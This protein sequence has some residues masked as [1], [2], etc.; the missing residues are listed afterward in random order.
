[1][2][3]NE[4]KRWFKKL[5]ELGCGA[6]TMVLNKNSTEDLFGSILIELAKAV[7]KRNYTS[8]NIQHQRYDSNNSHNHKQF[9]KAS[10]RSHFRIGMFRT[11]KPHICGL[12]EIIAEDAS[13]VHEINQ[14][15]KPP[16]KQKI[17]CHMKELQDL[18]QAIEEII[19]N[20][21]P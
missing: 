3:I 4:E 10:Q 11:T 13:I 5:S 7:A 1:M 14:F 20:I 12:E 16:R 15:N 8:Q 2:K 19:N 21:L 6:K 9:V 18:K 17:K